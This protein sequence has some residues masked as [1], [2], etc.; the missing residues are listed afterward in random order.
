MQIG[1]PYFRPLRNQN[2]WGWGLGIHLVTRHPGGFDVT[3]FT[4][5]LACLLSCVLNLQISCLKPVH[6][7]PRPSGL[8]SCSSVSCL[9]LFFSPRLCVIFQLPLISLDQTPYLHIA[10]S[11]Y[12]LSLWPVYL[13]E[14]PSCSLSNLPSYLGL[15]LTWLHRVTP[16]HESLQAWRPW[17]QV[18]TLSFLPSVLPPCLPT[19]SQLPVIF[20]RNKIDIALCLKASINFQFSA[21][22]SL[23]SLA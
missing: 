4:E 1:R 17:T 16:T 6:L 18:S 11:I 2:L 7:F 22:Y 9:C 21:E 10:S 8:N 5:A 19:S 15:L 14:P 3:T 23:N 20:L 12:S 13:R